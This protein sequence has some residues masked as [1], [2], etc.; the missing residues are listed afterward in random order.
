L[1][2][3][4]AREELPDGADVAVV[5]GDEALARALSTFGGAGGCGDLGCADGAQLG[6]EAIRE[7]RLECQVEKN[8]PYRR[9]TDREAVTEA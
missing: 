2:G 7:Q 1:L 6:V 9:S 4:V 5:D 8:N 3:V